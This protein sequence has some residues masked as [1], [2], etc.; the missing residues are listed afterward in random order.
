[1]ASQQNKKPV[2]LALI[3]FSFFLLVAVFGGLIFLQ[4][5]LNPLSKSDSSGQKPA[6]S[7]LT[8]KVENFSA[9]SKLPKVSPA[10]WELILVNRDNIKEEMHPELTEVAGV[11]VDSRIAEATTNFLTAAQSVNLNARLISGYRSVEEQKNLYETYVQQEMEARGIDQA[12]AEKVVQTYSQ[13]A[14]V[15]EHMTGLAVDLST[16]GAPNQMDEETA[17]QI[18]AIAPDY[19]FVLRYKSEYSQ[20]TGVGYED[21][22]FRYV[23]KE[24]ARYMTD[25]NLSLESYL[26]LLSQSADSED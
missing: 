16:I 2:S 13:P 12:A 15:S 1:M 3:F 4:E 14:G 22:H 17:K 25:Y 7:E 18:A 26:S 9:L 20:Q 5:K 8:K 21:W 23:G 11:Q 6:S 24:S 10:D 19:G